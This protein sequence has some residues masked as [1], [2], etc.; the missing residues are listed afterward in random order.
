MDYFWELGKNCDMTF[1]FT[2]YDVVTRMRNTHGRIGIEVDDL[3]RRILS[4]Y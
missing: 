3:R 1:F 2:A 4:L